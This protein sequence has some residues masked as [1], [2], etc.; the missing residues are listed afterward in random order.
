MLGKRKA[1]EGMKGAELAKAQQIQTEQDKFFAACDREEAANEKYKKKKNQRKPWG[2]KKKKGGNA[3]KK[4][5]TMATGKINAISDMFGL[6]P[7]SDSCDEHYLSDSDDS[8]GPP[9]MTKNALK[10]K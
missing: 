4:G 3:D 7:G 8:D 9:P 5:Q 1:M 6:D 2:D 10:K